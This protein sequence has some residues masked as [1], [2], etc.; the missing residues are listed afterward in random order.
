MWHGVKEIRKRRKIYIL[1]KQKEEKKKNERKK[2]VVKI[3][4]HLMFEKV[5]KRRVRNKRR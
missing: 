5:E 2:K 4:L 3:K 1:E